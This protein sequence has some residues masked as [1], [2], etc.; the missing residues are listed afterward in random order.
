MYHR[1]FT[2]QVATEYDYNSV[3]LLIV[4]KDRGLDSAKV[5][6]RFRMP[7]ELL[8]YWHLI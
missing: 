7:V 8:S 3:L 2:I 4:C 5:L 1:R 6:S